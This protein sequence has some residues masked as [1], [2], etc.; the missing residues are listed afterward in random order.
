MR[1]SASLGRGGRGRVHPLLF[2]AVLV[3][4]RVEAVDTGGIVV[5]SAASF[6]VGMPAKGSIASLF[7]TGVR[8]N[9]TVVAE[10]LP[11]PPLRAPR[12]RELLFPLHQTRT[13]SLI[14]FF[15]MAYC[16]S[17]ALL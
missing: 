10:T 6:E 9:S 12:C 14:T 11:L 2:A 5:V 8:V 3:C 1:V 17:W 7:C 13:G 16:T 4:S 15:W